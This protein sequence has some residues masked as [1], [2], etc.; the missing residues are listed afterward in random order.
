MVPSSLFLVWHFQ[1]Q[2]TPTLATQ[3]HLRSPPTLLSYPYR[4]L[5][6]DLF[7]YVGNGRSDLSDFNTG[8]KLGAENTLT[9]YP[10]PRRLSSIDFDVTQ[11]VN[12]QVS[13]RDAFAGFGIRVGNYFANYGTAGLGSGSLK[14][15]TVDIAEPT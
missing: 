8:V 10:F 1:Q 11:F 9:P 14:I 6:L 4:S 2:V 3:R 7:G 12:A 15:E 5:Y 13:N